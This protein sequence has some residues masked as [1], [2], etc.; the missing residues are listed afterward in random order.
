MQ[1]DCHGQG[2]KMSPAVTLAWVFLLPI[3]SPPSFVFL[4]SVQHSTVQVQQYCTW[5][6]SN[7]AGWETGCRFHLT[8]QMNKLDNILDRLCAFFGRTASWLSMH[9]RMLSLLQYPKQWEELWRSVG[10]LIP[11]KAVCVLCS[12]GR[13]LVFGRASSVP[14][15]G[16]TL[17][18]CSN[19]TQTLPSE[20]VVRV[21][22]FLFSYTL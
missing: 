8:C 21:I 17:L 10:E 12:A 1:I 2:F 22:F 18:L 11:N 5:L 9:T 7:P 15:Q 16:C 6:I 14:S 3:P 20:L 13:V 19:C 4:P